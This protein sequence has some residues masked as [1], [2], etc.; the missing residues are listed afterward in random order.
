[1]TG[2]TADGGTGAARRELAR[3]GVRTAYGLWLTEPGAR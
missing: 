2:Q 1:M 3:H